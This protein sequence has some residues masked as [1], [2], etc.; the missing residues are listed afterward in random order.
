MEMAEKEGGLPVFDTDIFFLPTAEITEWPTGKIGANLP[1]AKGLSKII[2][3]VGFALRAYL[4]GHSLAPSTFL[5][6]VVSLYWQVKMSRNEHCYF[7]L[8]QIRHF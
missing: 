3:Y 2:I 1:V 4:L 6:S 8:Q 5:T 7:M